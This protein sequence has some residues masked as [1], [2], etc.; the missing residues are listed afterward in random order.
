MYRNTEGN[1]KKLQLASKHSKK[2]KYNKSM[3]L[4]REKY[5][6]MFTIVF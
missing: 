6:T 3:L 1:H 2:R 4:K 5:S